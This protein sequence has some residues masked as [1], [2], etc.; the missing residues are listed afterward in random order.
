MSGNLD[1]EAIRQRIAELGQEH[2]DLDE[3]IA[4]LTAAPEQDELLL[5][6]LKKRK[7]QLKD[8]ISQLECL[9]VPDIPA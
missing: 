2:R 1:I 5:R 4:H 3:V 9:L 8:R 6:R 7:L